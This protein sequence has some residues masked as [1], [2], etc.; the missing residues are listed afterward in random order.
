MKRILEVIAMLMVVASCGYCATKSVPYHI[1]GEYTWVSGKSST[2]VT[3]TSTTANFQITRISLEAV[4]GYATFI[5]SRGTTASYTI[6]VGSG[7]V[8][9]SGDIPNGYSIIGSST[10]LKVGIETGATV[11]YSIRGYR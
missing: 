8:Y 4:G 6:Y 3:I 11:Y 10:Q 7:N 5:S 2:E 9:D 1:T